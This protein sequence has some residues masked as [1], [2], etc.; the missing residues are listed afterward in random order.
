MAPRYES[1][2]Y[3]SE[4]QYMRLLT[5]P[6]SHPLSGSP[7]WQLIITWWFCTQKITCFAPSESDNITQ[8][9]I[10]PFRWNS[11][12]NHRLRTGWIW[13]STCACLAWRV[14]RVE[15][16]VFY[17]LKAP[18]LISIKVTF[19]DPD[20]VNLIFS[21]IKKRREKE[22]NLWHEAV[23]LL[24]CDFGAISC[25]LSQWRLFLLKT[26]LDNIYIKPKSCIKVYNIRCCASIKI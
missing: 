7:R 20:G 9:S 17:D 15:K 23:N 25:Y 13:W 5:G 6:K 8:I 10:V 14:N 21:K 11:G 18:Q 24:S 16:D 19:E 2:E 3:W 22:C 26:A 4:I 12:F 1:F